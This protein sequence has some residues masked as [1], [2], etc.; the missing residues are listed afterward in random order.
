MKTLLLAFAVLFAA[1]WA[2][3]TESSQ[4]LED[5]RYQHA[6][7]RLSEAAFDY[8]RAEQLEPFDP[9]THLHLGAVLFQMGKSTEAVAELR[10]AAELDGRDPLAQALLALASPDPAERAAAKSRAIEI[11]P[12]YGKDG[13]DPDEVLLKRRLLSKKAPR[14]KADAE[15]FAS[16]NAG[17]AKAPE[18]AASSG[19]PAAA[20]DLS[21]KTHKEKAEAFAHEGRYAESILE[22]Q[23]AVAACE[24]K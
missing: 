15:R 20:P 4:L 5:G 11:D 7:G 17:P 9:Q 23:A 22:Y 14:S 2:R 21:F 16:P 6:Q 24:K 12:A 1:A 18:Q 13:F 8:R 19:A 10:R 3:A